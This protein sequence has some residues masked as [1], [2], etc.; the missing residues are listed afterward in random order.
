MKR[1]LTA[2][3]AL[4]LLLGLCLPAGAADG[5]AEAEVLDRVVQ[6]IRD[7]KTEVDLSGFSLSS[8]EAMDILQQLYDEPDLFYFSSFTVWSTNGKVTKAELKYREEFSPADTAV[9]E[10][11]VRKA[12]PSVLPGMSDLQ[13]A[14]VLHD[15]LCVHTAYDLD[16]YAAGNVPGASYTAYGALVQGLAV[17]QGYSMAYAALLRRCGVSAEYVSSARMGHGWVLVQLDGSWYHV[18]VTWDDPVQDLPGRAMHGYFLLSDGAVAD[19][20]HRHRGWESARTC[21]DTRYDAGMFWQTQDQP[22]CFTD[23]DTCWLLQAE[24][25]GRDLRISLMRRDWK[26][27]Q[28]SSVYT[29]RDYWRVWGGG[30]AWWTSAYA[31]LGLWDGRLFFNDSLHIYAYD[32]ADGTCETVFTYEGGE[33]YVY[34]LSAADEGIRWVLNKDPNREGETRMLVLDRKHAQAQEPLPPAEEPP[35]EEPL[36]PEEP[37]E[38]E[39]APRE[40]NVPEEIADG[41]FADVWE[42]DYFCAAVRWALEKNITK[43]VSETRFAPRDTCTRAQVVTFLYRAMGEP[44]PGS[45]ENPFGDVAETAYYRNAVL[46]AV[47]KGIT[48]GT[49]TDPETGKPLFSPDTKCSYAHILTFLWRA[50]TGKLDSGYGTWYSEPLD[51]AKYR[52]LLPDTLPGTDP[53]RAAE[54]CPRCDAVTYLWRALKDAA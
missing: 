35:E 39:N 54:N 33:G 30:G 34:G 42:K 8:R 3:L 4:V 51:W 28:A 43:G 48:L 7:W 45:G 41:P 10:E 5:G 12:L 25:S 36:P 49:G 22:I 31:G 2:V 50:L 46:W 17:C 21:T 32:P 11:A 14:L 13:K 16:H 29:F 24:G 27:G 40:E 52:G 15:Y 47:E 26:T 1:A 44:E 20:E 38:E 18:D 6:A 9:Y 19:G 23:A 37:P 53:D